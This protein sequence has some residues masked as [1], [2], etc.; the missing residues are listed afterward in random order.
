MPAKSHCDK[1]PASRPIRAIG[2]PCAANQ[3][4]SASGSLAT[5]AS[6]RI[7]PCA[8]TTHTCDAS[9]D[10]SIPAYFSMVIPHDAWRRRKPVLLV[11]TITLRRHRQSPEAPL[12]AGPLPH[13]VGHSVRSSVLCGPVSGREVDHVAPTN[14]SVARLECGGAD[15]VD[16]GEPVAA[17][18]GGSG[19]AGGG[20]AGGCRRAE[21]HSRRAEGRT[22]R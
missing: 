10:T 4:I 5:F 13:L 21:L 3:A 20:V 2:V 6:F 16:A 8:S 18:A 19:R 17:Y 7:L 22:P 1:G 12:D 15:G 14:E 9:K 11:N